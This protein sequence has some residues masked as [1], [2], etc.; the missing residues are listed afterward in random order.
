MTAVHASR[1]RTRAKDE[2]FTPAVL[3][4]QWQLVAAARTIRARH[5]GRLH[6]V[7]GSEAALSD[8][9]LDEAALVPGTA[10]LDL[11]VGDPGRAWAFNSAVSLAAID[12]ILSD[13]GGIRL[14]LVFEVG[15]ILEVG[16]QEVFDP[17]SP[18][19]QPVRSLA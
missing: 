7:G 3:P 14:D 19:S 1:S 12:E 2:V 15:A 13:E 8:W 4:T 9:G 11:R 10:G 17:S 18:G 5:A 6:D 16:A